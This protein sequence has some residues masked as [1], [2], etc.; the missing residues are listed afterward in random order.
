MQTTLAVVLLQASI[1]QAVLHAVVTPYKM[2]RPWIINNE[3]S[4]QISAEVKWSYTDH[5]FE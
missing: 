4:N 1:E 5:T 3:I 2:P